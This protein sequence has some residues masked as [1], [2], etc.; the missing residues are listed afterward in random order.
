MAHAQL[1]VIRRRFGETMRRD[2]WWVQPVVV[3]VLLSSFIGYATWAAFQ[4]QHY[5]YG[6]YLS[7]FYSSRAVRRLAARVV[8]TQAG[9]VAG[10]AGLLAGAADPAVPR[11]LPGDLLL[12][13]RRVLQG[14]LGRPA[15]L[16]RRRA[17]EGVPR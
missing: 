10:V 9:L 1:P 4:G 12:L 8:R 17:A 5:T 11:P 7:P 6:P 2:W 16:R 14:V 13:P 3:F 15:G